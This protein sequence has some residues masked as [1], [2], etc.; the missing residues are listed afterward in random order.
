[1]V[2]EMIGI[3]KDLT[4]SVFL[5]YLSGIF[6][7]SGGLRLYAAILW[8]GTIPIIGGPWHILTAPYPYW[9]T[10]LMATV[11]T[12][13]GALVL[14]ASYKIHKGS[15]TKFWGVFIILGSLIALFCAGSFGLGGIIGLIGGITAL[16]AKSK[17][18]MITEYPG[19]EL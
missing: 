3:Q 1:M 7:I 11:S 10:V 13:S 17:H 14:F 15:E 6:I 16:G 19:K 9:F 12:S 2:R 4:L 18:K 5:S 8:Q